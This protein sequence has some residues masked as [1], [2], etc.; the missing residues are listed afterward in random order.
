MLVLKLLLCFVHQTMM[1]CSLEQM[2]NIHINEIENALES[3]M[4]YLPPLLCSDACGEDHYWLCELCTWKDC[5]DLLTVIMCLLVLGNA[6]RGLWC[7]VGSPR[8][9]YRC[10]THINVKWSTIS[11]KYQKGPDYDYTLAVFRYSL[12]PINAY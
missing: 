7:H 1:I 4:R 8:V 5:E 3:L 9:C 2:Q 10:F 12:I 6:H 11:V